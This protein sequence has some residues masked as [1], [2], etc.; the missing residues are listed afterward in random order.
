MPASRTSARALWLREREQPELRDEPL[1]SPRADEVLVEARFGAI[2]RGT[3]RL[4]YLGRVPPSEHARMRAP[5]QVGELPF[6]VKY[7]Y[8]N[9]GRV[10]AGQDSLIGRDVFCLWPH[11]DVYVAPADA[12]TPLP[13]GVSA[14]RA[15]LAANMETAL[16]GV[17][18]AEL[19]AGDRVAVVGAGVVGCLVAYLCAQHP[20]CEVTLVDVDPERERIAHTLGVDFADSARCPG[21]CDVVFHAS[22][23]PAGLPTAL[24]AAGHEA[25]VVELSWYGDQPVSAPLGE[26]FH[27]KRLTLRSSQVGSL[28]PRQRPRW[29]Y[30]RRLALALSLLRDPALDTLFTSEG[31]FEDLPA[32]LPELFA[33]SYRGLCHRI[34]YA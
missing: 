24:A 10:L 9:V 31:R 6:P 15:V 28:P 30:R 25:R 26:G 2:S 18:D 13:E 34:R 7:G 23:H 3:E 4:V 22:G 8:V 20:G 29:T 33:P 19:C 21:D 12:V 27:I 17:W 11:Q 14:E 5:F 1:G 16:N 32:A